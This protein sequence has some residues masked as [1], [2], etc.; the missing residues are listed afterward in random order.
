MPTMTILN[1]SQAP[2][3]SCEK[4]TEQK[5]QLVALASKGHPQP[6]LMDGFYQTLHYCGTTQSLDHCLVGWS[7]LPSGLAESLQ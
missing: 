1:P 6:A 3:E 7:T 5:W 2:C 4:K